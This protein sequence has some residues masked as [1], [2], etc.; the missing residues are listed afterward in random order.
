[1]KHKKTV[2]VVLS[3]LAVFGCTVLLGSCD[4]TA[5]SSGGNQKTGEHVADTAPLDGKGVL[6]DGGDINF[7][8]P[9]V[10]AVGVKAEGEHQIVLGTDEDKYELSGGAVLAT[11]ENSGFT[12]NRVRCNKNADGSVCTLTFKMDF[13]NASDLSKIG[14]VITLINNRTYTCISV[15]SDQENWTDIG[16]AAEAG[17][18]GDYSAH[19]TNLL[20]NE[21]SDSNLYQCYYALGEYVTSSKVLYVKCHYSDAY[22][23]GLPSKVGTDVIGYAS[24]FD[25]FEIEYDYL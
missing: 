24:Y 23:T 4:N 3:L 18:H 19:I 25:S 22:N 21:V 10:T 20:G 13:S 16:Y 14:C 8:E 17:I 12:F 11:W 9:V 1:M 7:S 6:D 5:T 15:S 2:S